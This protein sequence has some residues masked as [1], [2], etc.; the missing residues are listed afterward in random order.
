MTPYQP[1]KHRHRSIRLSGYDYSRE[2]AYF[3]TV[4]T[5]NRAC[6]FGEIADGTVILTDEGRIVQNTWQHLPQHYP[7]IDLDEFVIMPN[8]IHAIICLVDV[9]GADDVHAGDVRAGFKPAPTRYP[10]SE[11][12]RGFKTFSARRIN[13]L[14]ATPDFPCGNAITTKTLSAT[15]NR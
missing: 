10:L 5:H 15:T 6:P 12:V 7:G 14:R 1:D 13:E 11:I 8:H 3:I 9:V 4:C 2:G